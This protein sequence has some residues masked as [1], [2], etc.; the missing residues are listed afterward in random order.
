VAYRDGDPASYGLADAPVTVTI[1]LKDESTIT[2]KVDQVRAG[3]LP[4]KA[5]WVEQQRVFLLRQAEAEKLMRGLDYY[6]K[7]KTP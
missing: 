7:P 5:A 6:V 2:L 1:R 3:E 4:R